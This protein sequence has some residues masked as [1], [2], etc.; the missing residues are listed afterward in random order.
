MVT[1]QDIEEEAAWVQR[2]FHLTNPTGKLHS[3]IPWV[4]DGEFGITA[5]GA[6]IA[7]F[8]HG[9]DRDV[10]LYFVNVHAAMIGMLEAQVRAWEFAA[11]GG[12]DA[13]RAFAE[14][15]AETS[16]AY[17]QVL[18]RLGKVEA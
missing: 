3:A 12:D 9:E 2:L 18:S 5:A 1:R 11:A 6:T 10:A 7:R 4:A 16:R 8:R 14:T 15:Q 17:A 13:V